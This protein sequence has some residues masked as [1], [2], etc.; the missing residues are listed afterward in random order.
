MIHT[1]VSA[2]EPFVRSVNELFTE[3]VPM[4]A[5]IYSACGHCD[6]YL[7]AFDEPRTPDCL[8]NFCSNCTQDEVVRCSHCDTKSVDKD[9]FKPISVAYLFNC[10]KV[11]MPTRFRK[12][13]CQLCRSQSTEFVYCENCSSDGQAGIL[14]CLSCLPLTH[15]NGCHQEHVVVSKNNHVAY[16][17]YVLSR[18]GL[19]LTCMTV[20]KRQ[21]HQADHPLVQLKAEDID[22]GLK[23]LLNQRHVVNPNNGTH[24]S[25]IHDKI[26]PS[27]REQLKLKNAALKSLESEKARTLQTFVNALDTFYK[28]K[29]VEV[30]E[31]FTD[32]ESRIEDCRNFINAQHF[33]DRFNAANS[34]LKVFKIY[35]ILKQLKAMP[36]YDEQDL[37]RILTPLPSLDLE[38]DMI[39]S[40]LPEF[41][42]ALSG[43]TT[44]GK[45]RRKAQY[46][47]VRGRHE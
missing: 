22:E 40:S 29:A 5:F 14:I 23:K 27:C 26:M 41:E 16:A 19:C 47:K 2:M 21:G 11:A 12:A 17:S 7:T 39:E 46:T 43:H 15:D 1:K 44:Q 4:S 24:M 6:G 20:V 28:K 33:S 34:N 30:D 37:A 18:Y 3:G 35:D 42:K 45:E 36:T 8:H 31:V 9:S 10:M 25:V 38:L 13:E 32:V